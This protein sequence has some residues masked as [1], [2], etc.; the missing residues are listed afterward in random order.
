VD[1]KSHQEHGH[2]HPSLYSYPIRG[3]AFTR[4]TNEEGP[5]LL[6]LP[7][8]PAMKETFKAL[9]RVYS[10]YEIPAP[11][12]IW[13]PD[14]VEPG[15]DFGVFDVAVANQPDVIEQIT[16]ATPN[17]NTR[18]ALITHAYTPE[19]EQ[20]CLAFAQAG[21]HVSPRLWPKCWHLTVFLK[22]Y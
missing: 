5:S 18:Y 9:Q 13:G 1:V 19:T 10:S 4:P 21:L 8:T 16:A 12:V 11:Q 7:E 6:L 15:E 20:V 22:E 2:I 17:R 14:P 3:A